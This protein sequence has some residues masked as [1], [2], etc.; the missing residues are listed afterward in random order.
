M[1]TGKGAI[2]KKSLILR[3]LSV[4]LKYNKKV[5]MSSC[6]SSASQTVTC[7][8]LIITRIG[9]NLNVMRLGPELLVCCFAHQGSAVF[10]FFSFAPDFKYVIRRPG[11]SIVGHL[12]ESVSLRF[13]LSSWWYP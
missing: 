10:F 1:V 11:N 9:Y 6:S 13:N 4:D 5:L 7:N 3:K 8:L 2:R 12:A